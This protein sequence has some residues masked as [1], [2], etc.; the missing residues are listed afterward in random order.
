MAV[1][2]RCRRTG[3]NNDPCFRIVATD[4]RFPRDGKFLEILGWYDPKK[5]EKNFYLDLD[6]ISK[7]QSNGAQVSDTVKSLMKRAKKGAMATPSNKIGASK[8]KEEKEKEQ[9]AVTEPPVSS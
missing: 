4:V 6:Q 5:K 1:K 3:A 7:W 8:E 9:V 2:I